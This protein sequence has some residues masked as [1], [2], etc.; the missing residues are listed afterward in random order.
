MAGFS[1]DT[2]LFRELGE[3]LVGRD[4]TALVELIKNAYDADASVV[5]IY[6]ESLASEHGGFIV[7]V[8][9]GTGIAESNF[10]RSFLR[11]ASRSKSENERRSRRYRRRFTGAKGIGRLAA[12]KLARVLEIQSVPWSSSPSHKDVGVHA[13]IDWDL[14]E[15]L[16][17][18]EDVNQSKA[19]LVNSLTY[20]GES[21]TPGTTITLSRLRR[22][23]TATTLGRFLAEVQTLEPPRELIAPLPGEMLSVQ[24]NIDI[25]K[26]RD[27][28]ASDPGFRL[29]LEGD[30]SGGDQYWPALLRSSSWI[31]EVAANAGNTDV[32]IEILPT[33]LTTNN[34]PLATRHQYSVP[35]PDPEN[36]PFFRARMLVREGQL[37]ILSDSGRTWARLASGIRVYQ[38]GF[39]VSPYGEPGNDWLSIDADYTDRRRK[40]PWMAREKWTGAED[41]KDVGLTMLRNDSYYGAVFLTETGSKNLQTLVNREGFVPNST[42]ENLVDLV[43]AATDIFIR[44]RAASRVPIRQE[45]REN[46]T[47][48]DGNDFV[49]VTN[50]N[51][52]KQSIEQASA[53]AIQATKL[54][55]A[56]N[57]ERARQRIEEAAR[58]I[59]QA[60]EPSVELISEDSIVRILASVGTQMAVFIHEINALLAMVSA[61][62]VA[63]N[64]VRD[65]PEISAVTRGEL[66][67]IQNSAS[68]LRRGLERQSSYLVAVVTPDARRRRSRQSFSSQFTAARRFV[69]RQ[70]EIRSTVIRND[71]DEDLKSP[72]MF[73]AELATVFSNLLTNAVK[74]AGKDGIVWGHSEKSGDGSVHIIIENTGIRINVPGS[75]IWFKPFE[76]T[77]VDVD[78]V[79]GQGMGLGL[80]IT[81]ATLEEYGGRIRFIAPSSEYA[82]AIEIW[83]PN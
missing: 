45:R 69:E 27:T 73:P 40:L 56:G 2:H 58:H 29:V 50:K 44:V 18:L 15:S 25:P 77:T 30:F 34:N 79:L 54:A 43:R 4:S 17:T 26:V 5:R 64:R 3:L 63:L 75:E 13:R 76:S 81:R 83:F 32:I 37:S 1:V 35:H 8:D 68:D 11:I 62:E 39:K 10:E 72:P 82:T 12:H 70:A 80:P 66:A 61:L 16:E 31:I 74:A 67:R 48:D 19:V 51:F 52:V 36:G 49:S 71:I 55:A 53:L 28:E 60:T 47:R 57:V 41:D 46:R 20:L 33:I 78:P 7:I 42:F 21:A 59:E 65:T 6:A 38:E 9:D 24:S 14:V 22:R 23:W